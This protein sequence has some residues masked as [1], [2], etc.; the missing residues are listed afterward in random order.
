MQ[1]SVNNKEGNDVHYVLKPVFLIFDLIMEVTS[2][3]KENN[4]QEENKS[5]DNRVWDDKK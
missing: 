5:R 4:I 2:S 1:K 3:C